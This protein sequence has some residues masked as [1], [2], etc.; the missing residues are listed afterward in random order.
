MSRGRVSW[1][2]GC[3]AGGG[4]RTTQPAFTSRAAAAHSQQLRH[5]QPGMGMRVVQARGCA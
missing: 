5:P 4:T 2:S 1:E 3:N